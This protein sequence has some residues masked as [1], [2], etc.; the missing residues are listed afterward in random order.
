VFKGTF[1]HGKEYLK[2]FIYLCFEFIKVVNFKILFVCL[3]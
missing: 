3:R 1:M 2:L